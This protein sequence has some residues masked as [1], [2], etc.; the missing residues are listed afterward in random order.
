MTYRDICRRLASAGIVE[1]ETDA[2][3]LLEH[4]CGVGRAA[5][6]LRR[7]EDFTCAALEAAVERRAGRYPLQYILGRWGFCGLELDVAPGVLIP[8]AD[9][10]LIVETAARELPRGGR[11]VD[12]GCGSGCI[13]LAILDARPDVAGVAVDLAPEALELTRRN[14]ERLGYS[15]RLRVLRGDMLSAELWQALRGDYPSGLDAVISNPP[16]IPHGEL[17]ELEPELAHEPVLALDGGADG[18]EPYRVLLPAAR[19][20]LS[21]GGVMIYE[22]GVGQAAAI[23]ALGAEL[24]LS[25]QILWDIEARDRGVMVCDHRG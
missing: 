2:A 6:P 7:D 4:F 10:E 9:T 18:L 19:S 16:Y 14:A 24:G 5:L 3:L 13:G 12:L 20:V 11:F 22:C 15:E 17:A 1:P 8:R 23:S 25:A 21:P